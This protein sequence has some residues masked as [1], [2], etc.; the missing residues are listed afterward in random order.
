VQWLEDDFLKYRKEW[1]KSITK[2]YPNLD[3]SER[4]DA[5]KSDNIGGFNDDRYYSFTSV[6]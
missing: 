4:A 1:E 2:A 5:N 3:P 6:F